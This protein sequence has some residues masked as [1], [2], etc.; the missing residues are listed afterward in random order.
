MEIDLDKSNKSRNIAVMKK[1]NTMYNLVIDTIEG[2]NIGQS[3][4]L[5]IPDNMPY[6][7]KY[8]SEISKRYSHKY[9]TKIVDG[10]MEI[11]RLK[12]SNIYSK[13]LE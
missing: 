13:E 2:M 7:R 3:R 10:K 5:P 4:T 6:F 1:S 8:L 9:T 11:M 12:Y